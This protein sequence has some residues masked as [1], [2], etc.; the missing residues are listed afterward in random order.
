MTVSAVRKSDP[1]Q[2]SIQVLDE[3]SVAALDKLMSDLGLHHRN[4]ANQAP[5]GWAPKTGDLISARFSEDNQW[6]R[7][8]VKRV[9]TLKKEAQIYL[10]DY[11]NEETTSF[12]YLR[13]LDPKFK[14][15][16]AQAKDA[17]LSFVK[18]V[19]RDSEHGAEA[20]G[21]F[22]QWAENRKLVANVDQRE[23]NLLHVRLIDPTNPIVADDPLACLNADLARE[24]LATLDKSLR[25]LGAYPAVVKKIEQATEGAKADRLGIFEF[26]D[27]S[28]D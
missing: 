10:I 3:K 4:Q 18:L 2:F 9:S 12:S 13:P 24:G 22:S 7:A 25:Y 23:G 17:R 19:P 15:L 1:F 28:E 8:R 6:Y 20:W 21:L 14:A 11:G 16:P 26:G 27:V 5:S